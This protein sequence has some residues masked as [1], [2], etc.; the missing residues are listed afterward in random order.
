MVKANGYFSQGLSS[1]LTK[2][3]ELL[4]SFGVIGAA[5]SVAGKYALGFA[6]IH[7]TNSWQIYTLAIDFESLWVAKA[8]MQIF[9]APSWQSF[10]SLL[11]VE[12]IS[13]SFV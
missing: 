11:F 5:T 9:F 10:V 13:K 3:S 4:K 8:I 1:L 12:T 6:K 7:P 2:A